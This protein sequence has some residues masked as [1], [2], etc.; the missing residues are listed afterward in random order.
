MEAYQGKGNYE[1][2]Q[3]AANYQAVRA[4]LEGGQG[5]GLGARA[6]D[7]GDSGSLGTQPGLALPGGWETLRSEP[8]G[9][10]PANSDGSCCFQGKHLSFQSL[11]VQMVACPG[12]AAISALL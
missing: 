12:N 9:F 10:P 6:G 5:P 1:R 8:C 2:I 7:E 11:D 3:L 4:A